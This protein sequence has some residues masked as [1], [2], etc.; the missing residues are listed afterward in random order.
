MAKIKNHQLF[1][2]PLVKAVRAEAIKAERARAKVLK[3]GLKQY[4]ITSKYGTLDKLLSYFMGTPQE[5]ITTQEPHKGPLSRTVGVRVNKKT[6]ITLDPK[7]SK[8]YYDLYKENASA[9]QLAGIVYEQEVYDQ[10]KDE[11][12]K[13]V[14]NN[15]SIKQN[16]N[17][18][19]F[20]VDTGNVGE[21][22]DIKIKLPYGL[23]NDYTQMTP[24]EKNRVLQGIPIDVKSNLSNFYLMEAGEKGNFYLSDDA[25]KSFMDQASRDGGQISLILRQSL[26]ELIIINTIKYKL[27]S[28]DYPVYYGATDGQILLSSQLASPGHGDFSVEYDMPGQDIV[29][30][31][32]TENLGKRNEKAT[33]TILLSLTY[34]AI[35]NNIKVRKVK[36][37]KKA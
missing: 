3:D 14:Q 12:A 22:F 4:N 26:E 18:T 27:R 11:I 31:E 20:K 8:E 30:T 24:D 33:E 10:V 23:S 21:G 32:V 5:I 28:N 13:I 1:N 34:E 16:R 15:L 25:A 2:S 36:Y 17:D 19:T 29:T 6:E 7:Q 9:S 35:I 37:A